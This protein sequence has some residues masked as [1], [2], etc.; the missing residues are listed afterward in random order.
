MRRL[1]DEPASI[2]SRGAWIRGHVL[3][4]GGFVAGIDGESI[5][6]KPG[7]PFMVPGFVD[8]HVHGGGGG[9]VM[10]GEAEI[11]RTAAFHARHGTAALCA[12][13][14]TAPVAEITSALREIDVVRRDQRP[15]EATILGAHIEGP[16]INALKLGGQPPY[17]ISPDLELIDLWC[18]LC[19]VRIV[20]LAPEL[21]GAEVAIRKLARNGVRVQVGHSLATSAELDAAAAWGVSGFTHLFN[22]A[23]EMKTREPGISGWALSRAEWAE[24]ICDLRHVHPDM[25]KVAI[26]SVT[27]PYFITDCCSAGG[28]PDGHHMLG[29]NAVEKRDGVVFLRGTEQIAASILIGADAFKNL[30]TIGEPIEVAV[31]MT[32]S[33]PA[34]YLG[35]SEYGDIVAG[36]AASIVEFDED[37]ELNTVW[38]K[39]QRLEN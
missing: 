30:I 6:G 8:L 35:L 25:L 14:L 19:P 13:T 21:D 10:N 4:S 15:D 20:T 16:F 31:K 38:L 1:N 28:Q 18:G 3:E 32:S 22:A 26:K 34:E 12:T 24:L 39:G 17:A 23:T 7:G 37:F 9:D 33:R 5:G 29:L 11:R 2:Y 36:R 27:K